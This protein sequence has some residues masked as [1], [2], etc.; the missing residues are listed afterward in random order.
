[1]LHFA[2]YQI[3]D[4]EKWYNSTTP[5][6]NDTYSLSLF[7]TGKVHYSQIPLDCQ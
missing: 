3:S 6:T 1:M 5:K 4:L 2:C 7:L